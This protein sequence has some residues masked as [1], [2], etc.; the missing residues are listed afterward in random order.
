M[1]RKQAHFLNIVMI[2]LLAASLA[3]VVVLTVCRPVSRGLRG[4]YYDSNNWTGTT[5]ATRVDTE[6]T[7]TTLKEIREQVPQNIF[8]VEWDGFLVI[9]ETGVYKF[10]TESDDG[11][12]I[13]IDENPVV[14]NGGPHGL[15]K[16]S[17]AIHL[18]KGT[19]RI[20]I[21]YSQYGGFAALTVRW[22]RKPFAPLPLTADVLLPPETSM[23]RFWLYTQG[24]TVLP[25]L[26]LLWGGL[27]IVFMILS[28]RALRI[29]RKAD[30]ERHIWDS[31]DSGS[32][33]EET[34]RR[35]FV[36][37]LRFAARHIR[38]P[39]VYFWIIVAVY[40]GIIFLTLSY[41][42]TFSDRMIDRFGKDIFSHITAVT[43][44][45]AGI[46]LFLYFIR[47]KTQRFSRLMSFLLIIALYGFFLNQGLREGIYGFLTWLGVDT[48]FW[49]ALDLYP[50][51][52]GEKV[53]FLEYGLLGLLLCK[54][55][56]YHIKN[57]T[58]Y[59]LAILSVYMIGITD[60]GIQWALPGRVGE[61]RDI[62]MNFT[63]GGLAILA[64]LL[65]IR[66]RVFRQEFQ[67]SSLRPLCYT[68]AAAI[69]Y[70]GIF[71]QVV[72]GFGSPIFLPDSGTEFVSG[73]SEYELLDIDKRL[74][75][76]RE[77][78]FAEDIPKSQLKVY[79]YEAKRHHYLRNKAYQEF[80]LF[81]SYC[82]QEILKTYFRGMIGNGRIQVFDYDPED[83]IFQP[84]PSKSVFYVSQAQELAITA[85]SQHTL[86]VVVSVS[87]AFL[88]F[89]ATFWP[90]SARTAAR[91]RAPQGSRYLNRRVERL[92]LRP[93][94]GGILLL[95]LIL[96]LYSFKK[97]SRY[98]HT[99]LLIL[100]VDSTQPD[101]WS[102]YG[103]DKKTTP[104]FDALAQEGVLFSNA[105]VP[106][107]W[108]I[109]SLA[110]L[111]TGVNPN[112][113]GIDVRGKLMDP[114][115]PTL[116]EALEQHGY[117][118][119]DTSY[120]L[121]EPSINSVFKKKDISPEV[122]LSEGRSEE[123]YL[124][125]WMEAHRDQPFFGWV[126]F[127]TSHLPYRATSPYNRLFLENIDPDILQDEQIQLVKSNIIVRKGEVEFDKE[128]HT[129]A[130][131]A[132]YAQ[133]LRQQD[134][135]L[136]KVLMK[137]DELGLRDNTIIVIT[138]DHGE[139][140]LEHGFI[141][142]ASTSW[143]TTVYDDLIQVP[144]LISYPKKL[145]K[146]QRIEAQVRHID[147]MPTVL[148][149]LEIPF[150]K[151]IQ[152]KSY[153]SLI[154]G[155]GDFQETAFAET[156]PC[157][158]SCPKRLEKNRLR[159]VRTNEWKLVSVYKDDTH[160]TTYELYHLQ[161]DPGETHNVID[162]Y[163]DIVTAFKQEMHYWMEEAPQKFAY[164]SQ[165]ME[166]KHYLD[167]DVEVRPIVLFPKVGTVLTPETYEKRVLVEWVGDDKA[168]Y[169][170]EYD[171]GKGGY[172]M[173]GELEVVGTKQ[174]FGPFP[175][176]IWQALPLYNPWKFRIVLK[177]YPQYPSEWITF[178]MKDK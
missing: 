124:L 120:T 97:T 130:I 123:S 88:C 12:L 107:S 89:L 100:T 86:W 63:S 31:P 122:A 160:E 164:T 27:V 8:S 141:G 98:T 74:V 37:P 32:V 9:P 178:E 16:K 5:S 71:L 121:T 83:F 50:I 11:S 10:V 55:L 149:M 36:E 127:H 23:T 115:I 99:N 165:K 113:H 2:I 20:K 118:I 176:D 174:W 132:L 18:I 175:E 177:E 171:I 137:L 30:E 44:T 119:G 34:L 147:L 42:R 91:F 39:E 14:N 96:N 140:L 28:S 173:T 62:W 43:L 76:R 143:D 78:T 172:H 95:V 53:H 15:E 35:M 153:L 151:P 138:A 22:A 33:G 126:H 111:L 52:A 104:F 110:S 64:V 161:D 6:F 101:Y 4:T 148:D 21:R 85:F 105:I 155:T 168:E 169:V 48:S 94:F 26:L 106:T 92:V 108:T 1:R 65:V 80:R 93:V 60:E 152:G 135:K 102:A 58:A 156:T 81:E 103:Y 79:T 46:L 162:E 40:S 56:R 112:V 129:P 13:Y 3:E 73:F 72:H 136:G 24:K 84:D 158:Y 61:Y 154:L 166:H 45:G 7:T 41:A 68:L 131:R 117:L 134:A 116:F 17:G 146:G 125:S 145:P 77:G 25:F 142:H 109:P 82:E 150:D 128:R 54:A 66:P 38:R 170:I 133:T 51:Y 159:A 70:T 90:V 49:E 114:R 75:Q 144:L 163:P 139:E 19:H 69:L 67:W 157:G 59:L 47:L 57:K 167:V 29:A 87:T